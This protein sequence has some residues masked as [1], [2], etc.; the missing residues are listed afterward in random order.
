MN[1]AYQPEVGGSTA[2]TPGYNTWSAFYRHYRV[3]A[4]RYRIEIVNKEAFPIYC[5]VG[6]ST[7]DPGTSVV[8]SSLPR[9]QSK[10]LSPK[11]GL[12][13]ISFRGFATQAYIVGS[14]ECDT[15]D[16]HAAIVTANPTDLVYFWIGVQ[17][18]SGTNMTNGVEYFMR[19]TQYVQ[20]YG[21]Q[22]TI[23]FQ[24]VSSS[25]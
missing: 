21:T 12:D 25:S 24:A 23:A 15:D 22:T 4:F 14:N 3:F 1:S 10:L 5:Y 2:S 17:N 18:A 6:S 9:S 13:R 16:T 8:S 20:F 11:G 19:F 7:V